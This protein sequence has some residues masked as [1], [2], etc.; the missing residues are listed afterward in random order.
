MDSEYTLD[1]LMRLDAANRRLRLDSS[2]ENS[3]RTQNIVF[4]YAAPKVGGTT[5][6]SSLRLWA[7]ARLTVLHIH[8]EAMLEAMGL[9]L[10]GGVS[11]MDV[12]RY[13]R[14]LGRNV[15]VIDVF[16]PPAERKMSEFFERLGD[17]HF[18]VSDET[19]AGYKFEK[20]ERRFNRL[21]PWLATA[22]PFSERYGCKMPAVFPHEERCLVVN[23]DGIT[24]VKLRLC[25]ADT[26]WDK[27][28]SALFSTEIRVVRDYEGAK[29][30]VI[31]GL[32]EQFKAQ[33]RLPGNYVSL[34]KE[35]RGLS[36]YYS[37]AEREAYLRKACERQGADRQPF[38][39]A[40]Y[41]L[42]EE[43]SLENAANWRIQFDHYLDCGCICRGCVAAR[44]RIVAKVRASCALNADDVVRHGG[45]T[46]A[47]AAVSSSGKTYR[48]P[49]IASLIVA[50]RP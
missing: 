21:W 4:V 48:S 32:Y 41:A 36:Y 20:L 22:D 28:L 5:L 50:A 45:N 17:H 25:D 2:E 16:R 9:G 46:T 12:V 10:G 15:W 30:S 35:D 13:N 44:T 43:L 24:F 14:Y 18:N 39:A 8:D 31:G 26:T 33:Y 11:V 6:V 38:S 23:E 1:K 49:S 19:L 47:S 37:A 27:I 29:K 40:E 7:A 42:Y 34:L 3:V